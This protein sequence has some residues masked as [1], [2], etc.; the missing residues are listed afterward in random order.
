MDLESW[1]DTLQARLNLSKDTLAK[2]GDTIQ[3][4]IDKAEDKAIDV[5]WYRLWV[6]NADLNLSFLE[7]ENDKTL[8]IWKACL[9]KEDELMAY[10]EAASGGDDDGDVNSKALS[11]SQVALDVEIDALLSDAAGEAENETVLPNEQSTVNAE[12][13]LPSSQ[14]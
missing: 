11:K 4:R 6:N 1:V 7:S 5:A 14:L 2:E 10:S 8:T 9:A 3:Q 12:A 13:T